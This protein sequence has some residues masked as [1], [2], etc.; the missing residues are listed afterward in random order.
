MV[1]VSVLY[2]RTSGKKFDIEYYKNHHMQLVKK[3]LAPLTVEIDLG[4]PNSRGQNSPYIAIGYMTFESVDELITKYGAAAKELRSD[5]P[6]Y[7]DIEP[8]MQISEVIPL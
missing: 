6:N 7:T 2:P 5:I 4:I 3:R 1:R 8:V